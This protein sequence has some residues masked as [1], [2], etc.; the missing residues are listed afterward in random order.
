MKHLALKTV[1]AFGKDLQ[2]GEYVE[3]TTTQAES[4]NEEGAI[5]PYTVKVERP[6]KET[7]IKK[8]Q[9]RSARPARV[10]QKKIVNK[11]GKTAK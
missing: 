1:L 10:S 11:S 4:L 3:L 8:K 7:K 5:A 2:V 6:P 9:S